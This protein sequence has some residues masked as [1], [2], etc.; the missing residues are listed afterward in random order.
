MKWQS[1]WQGVIFT[2]LLLTTVAAPAQ[3]TPGRSE[4]LYSQVLKEKRSFQVVLPDA[5]K[6]HPEQHFDTIYVLDGDTGYFLSVVEFL[7]GEGFMPPVIVVGVPSANADRVSRRERDLTPTHVDDFPD[8]GGAKNYLAFLKTELMP[9]VD[10]HYP[11]NGI[12]LI[13]GHSWGGLFLMYVLTADPSVFSGYLIGDPSMWWSRFEL[14]KA[15]DSKLSSVPSQGKTI[16]IYGRTG[17]GYEQMGLQT[18]NA[19][20]RKKAPADLH[21][22]VTAY[23]DETHGSVRLKGTYDALKY[24]Y[25]GYTTTALV[26]APAAGILLEGKPFPLEVSGD[27]VNERFDLRYTTDGTIPNSS[28][29][30]VDNFLTIANPAMTKVKMLS[31]SG[32]YDQ[33]LPH[34]FTLGNALTPIADGAIDK[35]WHAVFYPFHEWADF[36]HAKAFTTLT[37][38]DKVTTDSVGGGSF[39]GSVKR[40]VYVPD[41][42]YYVLYLEQT[43]DE[44]RMSIGGQVFI[45]HDGGRESGAQGFVVPLRR[46]VYSFEVAFQHAKGAQLSLTVYQSI[47]GD[48]EWWKNPLVKLECDK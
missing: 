28:S 30:K 15:L 1:V 39:A 47:N 10:H 34:Q 20:F 36:Q 25:Q 9:Y 44:V 22:K 33:V 19:I 43:S 13:H 40:N 42:G 16:S 21:W 12:T 14:Q 6:E 11:T 3:G 35:T 29:T 7:R 46:G 48:P 2:L 8:S 27:D 5:A 31:S 32:R 4:S 45:D 37:V 18:V 26:L 23:A 24:A 41:D 17:R 38:S